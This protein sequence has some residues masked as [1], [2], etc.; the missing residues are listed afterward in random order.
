MKASALKYFL[1][2]YCC[3]SLW[4]FIICSI[5]QSHF[6]RG[7]HTSLFTQEKYT[8]STLQCTVHLQYCQQNT[9]ICTSP[10]HCWYS[11]DIHECNGQTQSSQICLWLEFEYECRL[12]VNWSK[13]SVWSLTS[14][15][16][17]QLFSRQLTSTILHPRILKKKT[18]YFFLKNLC[19][20]LLTLIILPLPV[21]SVLLVVS[22]LL[23]KTSLIISCSSNNGRRA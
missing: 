7:N 2:W 14:S 10:S 6:T 9:Q 21:K 22:C 4:L 8:L 16:Y 5:K 23:Y 11:E 12:F 17:S 1:C 18:A 13:Q 20:H 15:N 19:R 3:R